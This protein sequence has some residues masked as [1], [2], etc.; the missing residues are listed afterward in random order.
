MLN[1]LAEFIR[2]GLAHFYD[3]SCLNGIQISYCFKSSNS[4]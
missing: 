2:A 4:S 3:K 1:G